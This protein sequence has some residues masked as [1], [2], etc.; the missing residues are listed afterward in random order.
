MT[1]AT[2]LT[3]APQISIDRWGKDHWST[4]AYIECRIVDHGGTIK[5][6]QLRTDWSINR[7]RAHR[8][9]DGARYPT[10]LRGGDTASPHDDWSCIE[11]ME[12][13][14]LIEWHGTGLHPI[15][16]LTPKGLEI[17]QALR[18]HKASGGT[19]ATF[20]WPVQQ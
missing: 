17:A 2:A 15:F 5:N 3:R 16:K 13:E 20:V 9:G 14:G 10:R 6:E 12:R 18:T 19:F 1:D 11:D 8:G 4:L 7:H